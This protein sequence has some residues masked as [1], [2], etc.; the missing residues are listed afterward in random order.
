MSVLDEASR[1]RIISVLRKHKDPTLTEERARSLSRTT[2][3]K[4][5]L[6]A[7]GVGALIAVVMP[8]ESQRLAPQKPTSTES[9]NG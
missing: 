5:F 6:G 1:D 9:D 3:G 7:V 4:Y 2:G 8:A